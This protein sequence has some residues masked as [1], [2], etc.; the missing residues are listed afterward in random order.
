QLHEQFAGWIEAGSAAAGAAPP[1]DLLAYHYGQS[2][3]T[4]KQR[5]YYRLAGD[6][7]A[8]VY[9]HAAAIG[10]YERLLAL[11]P[12]AEAIAE[13]ERAGVLLALGE[14]LERS[15]AWD[16]A[17]TRYAEILD[18]GFWILEDGA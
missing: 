18:F 3:N 5:E 17:A 10:Y 12:G 9:A 8:T 14:V 11:L 2:A 1:L 7:A 16:A 13:Q 4:G 15:G 6:A